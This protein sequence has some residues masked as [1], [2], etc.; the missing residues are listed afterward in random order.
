VWSCQATA[1]TQEVLVPHR[2]APLSE[3]GRLR[4]ARLAA[5]L[6]PLVTRVTTEDELLALT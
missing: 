3:L 2:N 6:L 5:P 1:P 4:L